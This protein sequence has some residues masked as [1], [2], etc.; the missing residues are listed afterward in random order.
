MR[1]AQ[2]G[3]ALLGPSCWC[4]CAGQRVLFGDAVVMT[5][6][7]DT[8]CQL[9]DVCAVQEMLRAE[10]LPALRGKYK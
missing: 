6:L 8:T 9:T 5:G 3:D 1:V 2:N 7:G 4:V 10:S